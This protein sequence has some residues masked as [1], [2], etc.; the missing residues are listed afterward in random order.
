MYEPLTHIHVKTALE[1]GYLILIIQTLPSAI[2][3]MD[4]RDDGR[5]NGYSRSMHHKSGSRHSRSQSHAPDMLREKDREGR[6]GSR[7]QHDSDK[8]AKLEE[9]YRK[10]VI[11]YKDIAK[12]RDALVSEN[13]AYRA[14]EAKWA[15]ERKSLHESISQI[16]KDILANYDR[17]QPLEDNTITERFQLLETAIAPVY[18]N[19]KEKKAEI[20]RKELGDHT[21]I[22][23]VP[24]KQWEKRLKYVVRS[25]IWKVLITTVFAHPFIHFGEEVSERLMST[26]TE[27]FKTG[28]LLL[29]QHKCLMLNRYPRRCSQWHISRLACRNG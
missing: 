16:Q 7:H 23:D 21:L 24:M 2:D 4:H 11:E 25:V 19:I 22:S 29:L 1:V 15:E 27:L 17:F 26:W 6:E 5:S 9:L 20:L 13:E 10:L 8:Q 12:E 28:K 3:E 18:K 14:K